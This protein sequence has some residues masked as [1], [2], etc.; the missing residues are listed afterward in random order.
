MI[1]GLFFCIVLE[2]GHNVVHRYYIKISITRGLK[3]YI[4]PRHKL[5]HKYFKNRLVV[6]VLITAHF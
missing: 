2:R 4:I 6:A 5:G 1:G 3:S